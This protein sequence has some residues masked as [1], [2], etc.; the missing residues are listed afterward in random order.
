MINLIFWF[1][2]FCSKILMKRISGHFTLNFFLSKSQIL[3]NQA[4]KSCIMYKFVQFITYQLLFINQ[5]FDLVLDGP[6]G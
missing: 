1:T 5:R 2:Q 3:G 6:L 4:I